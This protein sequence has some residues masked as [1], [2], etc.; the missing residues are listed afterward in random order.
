MQSTLSTWDAKINRVY[1]IYKSTPGHSLGRV[2][3]CWK[4]KYIIRQIS[5]VTWSNRETSVSFSQKHPIISA[6]ISLSRARVVPR[7]STNVEPSSPAHSYL[8]VYSYMYGWASSK[9]KKKE[10]LGA[11]I[12]AKEISSARAKGRKSLTDGSSNRLPHTWWQSRVRE[13]EKLKYRRSGSRKWEWDFF[14]R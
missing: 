11:C 4:K 1:V 6:F 13:L 7:L 10:G 5:V 9:K 8:C 3:C 14:S 2:S 12:S